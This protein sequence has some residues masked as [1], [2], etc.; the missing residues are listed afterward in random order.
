ML[1][2]SKNG[3]AAP[4][5]DEPDVSIVGRN[6][7][8]LRRRAGLTLGQ[9]AQ[10]AGVSSPMLSRIERGSVSPSVATLMKLARDA[11]VTDL[12]DFQALPARYDMPTMDEAR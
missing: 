9:L 7:R 6:L 2:P 11:G 4:T 8:R 3:A 12:P 10:A 5:A 1:L